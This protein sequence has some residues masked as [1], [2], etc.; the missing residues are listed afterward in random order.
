M[1]SGPTGE[2]PTTSAS[3]TASLRPPGTRRPSYTRRCPR[4]RPPTQP[5]SPRQQPS[6]SGCS[7]PW[8][9]PRRRPP[10]P[11]RR[12]LFHRRPHRCGPPTLPSLQGSC[13]SCSSRTAAEAGRWSCAR[14]HARS[15]VRAPT[16]TSCPAAAGN[17]PSP[18]RAPA[19]SRAAPMR[20]KSR[21][22]RAC[23]QGEEQLRPHVTHARHRGIGAGGIVADLAPYPRTPTGLGAHGLSNAEGAECHL[24]RSPRSKMSA[25]RA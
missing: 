20:R 17:T 14:P 9:L 12:V 13:F 24:P 1:C 23:W 2:R 5:A 21:G 3:R 15:A 11:R 6:C 4:A 18:P 8:L 7:P 22:T 10:P 25:S 19:G 16:G